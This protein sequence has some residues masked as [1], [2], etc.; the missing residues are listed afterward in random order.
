MVFPND[1]LS[2]TKLSKTQ[3][4]KIVKS[5]GVL[6]RLSSA[7]LG[8]VL[9]ARIESAKQKELILGKNSAKYFVNKGINELNEKITTSD[10]TT[11]TN[12]E[13]KD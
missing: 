6:F 9:K 8:S 1:S 2:N 4:S 11:L 5:E 10:K 13:I 12:N 3:L 7:F